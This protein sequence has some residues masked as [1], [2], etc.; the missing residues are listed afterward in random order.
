MPLHCM[1]SVPIQ[2]NSVQMRENADQNNSELEHFLCSA[3]FVVKS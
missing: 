3:S 2:S 1:K